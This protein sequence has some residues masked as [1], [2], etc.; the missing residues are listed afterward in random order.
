[1]HV[2]SKVE[3]GATKY[4]HVQRHISYLCCLCLPRAS[5]PSGSPSKLEVECPREGEVDPVSE[6]GDHQPTRVAKV[7]V[8]VLKLRVYCTH[9]QVIIPV[10]PVFQNGT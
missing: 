3:G 4:M 7:L 6:R 5:R 9:L 1:M 10:I 8:A 2:Q